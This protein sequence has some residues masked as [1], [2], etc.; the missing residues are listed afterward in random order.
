MI[1]FSYFRAPDQPYY[2]VEDGDLPCTK[3]KVRSCRIPM[4]VHQN[5]LFTYVRSY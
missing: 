4:T 1:V 3:N 2:E 5:S